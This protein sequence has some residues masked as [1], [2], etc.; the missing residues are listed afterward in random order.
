MAIKQKEQQ[1]KNK[2]VE[3]LSTEYKGESLILGILATITA[4][5][6]VMIIGNVQGFHIPADFPVLGGS[7]NDMIF[8]WTVLVI[9]MLGLALVIY[10]FFLPAFPELRKITWA[11]WIEFLDNAVRVL[12]FVIIVTAFVS[13]LDIIILRLIEG[14]L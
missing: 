6:A 11:G 14:I 13:A 5:L 7:P 9:A 8:A 12:I 4:A 2:L 10:P 1:P 3:I